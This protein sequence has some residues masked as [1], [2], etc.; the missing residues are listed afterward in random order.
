MLTNSDRVH[1]VDSKF[2]FEVSSDQFDNRLL[3]SSYG[4][5]NIFVRKLLFVK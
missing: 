3:L 4:G 1:E 2:D 5:T